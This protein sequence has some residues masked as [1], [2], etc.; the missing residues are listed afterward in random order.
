MKKTGKWLLSLLTKALIIILVILLLPM[1][2]TLI[3]RIMPDAA[4]EIQVQ[5]M[6]LEQKLESSKPLMRKEFL[7][8]K[9]MWSFWEPSDPQL[10]GTGIQPASESI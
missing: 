8:Q 9:P 4:G 1:A 10:Y 6:V 3:R 5:S 2:R 7:R